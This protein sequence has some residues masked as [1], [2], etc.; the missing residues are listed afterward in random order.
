MSELSTKNQ[1]PNWKPQTYTMGA[2]VGAILGFMAAYLYSRAAEEDA[3]RSGGKP[4][5]IGTGE[6]ITL[7]LAAL[8][9]IRQIAE[10][11]KPSK[12]S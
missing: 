6:M 12:K 2:I 10:L 1:S 4:K 3:Q 8:G 5:P 7:G 11:G 9:L